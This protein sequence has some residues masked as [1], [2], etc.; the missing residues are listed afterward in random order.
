MSV[1]QRMSVMGSK[2][3]FKEQL[4]KPMREIWVGKIP[5]RRAWQPTPVF[6]PGEP[7][8]QRSLVGYSPWGCRAGHN[9]V[10]KHNQTKLITYLSAFPP[11]LISDQREKSFI[12]DRTLAYFCYPPHTRSTLE[13]ARNLT[14]VTGVMQYAVAAKFLT[15]QSPPRF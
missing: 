8:G 10:T 2:A 4:I 6:L 5:R 13:K 9:S 14:W 12:N 15:Q 7:H 1:S 11:I 3:K